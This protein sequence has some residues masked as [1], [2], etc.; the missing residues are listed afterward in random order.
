MLSPQMHRVIDPRHTKISGTCA[1]R[2]EYLI[3]GLVRPG[4]AHLT[5]SQ[6]DRIIVGGGGFRR[7]GPDHRRGE[8][9][10]HQIPAG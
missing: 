4:P 3:D 5:G 1:F 6:Y 2:D 9:N 10:P 7:R 8:G